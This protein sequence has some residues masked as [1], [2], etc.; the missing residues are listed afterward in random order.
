[1][2]NVHIISD[3]CSRIAELGTAIRNSGD[4]LARMDDEVEE[5]DGVH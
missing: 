1:M 3:I 2:S 4:E 5:Q